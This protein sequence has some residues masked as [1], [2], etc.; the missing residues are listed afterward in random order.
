MCF[1]NSKL[2]E[3]QPGQLFWFIHRLVVIDRNAAKSCLNVLVHLSTVS[4]SFC[5]VLARIWV[6]ALPSPCW[7]IVT[8]RCQDWPRPYRPQKGHAAILQTQRPRAGWLA[9]TPSGPPAGKPARLPGLGLRKTVVG[10][11]MAVGRVQ[12]G[13][14]EER[15]CKWR[16]SGSETVYMRDGEGGDEPG[17]SAGKTES[18]SDAE[19]DWDA[20]KETFEGTDRMLTQLVGLQLP[21]SQTHSFLKLSDLR[22][23]Q[24]ADKQH[25]CCL[26]GPDMQTCLHQRPT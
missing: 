20:G 18:G 9:R 16:E 22:S 4:P 12:A 24:D 6:P 11:E 26:S 19:M 10:V 7:S 1:H 17:G 8:D 13:L 25:L 2:S 3:H 15:G 23:V 5:C 21:P 14:I